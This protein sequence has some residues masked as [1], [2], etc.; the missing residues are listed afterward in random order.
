MVLEC[1]GLEVMGVAQQGA[2]VS[3]TEQSQ[4][5]KVTRGGRVNGDESGTT[6][7]PP[8][9]RFLFGFLCGLVDSGSS[10]FKPN[11]PYL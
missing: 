10:S 5:R 9:Q 8:K 4:R 11:P 7:L 6:K 3:K 1:V 2:D